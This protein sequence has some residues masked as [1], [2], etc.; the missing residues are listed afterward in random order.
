MTVNRQ[1]AWTEE[2]DLL[3]A[4]VILRHIREGSTQLKAFEEVGD[5]LSRTG[6]ACGFRWNSVVRK[7]YEAGIEIAKAQRQ[8]MKKNNRRKE[9]RNIEY[10]QSI[11]I[12]KE[13][14]Q[15]NPVNFTH[16]G[17]LQFE[18][19]IKYLKNVKYEHQELKK[20]NVYLEK[21]LTELEEE[22]KS[23]HKELSSLRKERNQ[24]DS[25]TEDYKALVQIMDR[26][27]KLAVLE[28]YVE[29]KPK[30][31]MDLN[32]NLERV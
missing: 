19:V 8:A 20:R 21:R 28:D 16:G 27:R 3:L 10:H 13:N 26:A 4:E 32:G 11:K 25:V 6:A 7:K 5:K 12:E 17:T 31:K 18:D 29:E 23:L 14:Y 22:N 2:D 1:D 24:Y 15:S 9:D 30:F